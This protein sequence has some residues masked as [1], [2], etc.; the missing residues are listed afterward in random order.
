MSAH[1][2]HREDELLDALGRGYV[3]AELAAHIESCA[4][5]S[6][7]QLVAGALLNDRA[8]AV[9]EAPVPAAGT[10][11]WRMQLRHRHEAQS[12][13]RRTLL[14]GQALTLAIAVGLMVVLFGADVALTVRQLV[15]SIH[16][17][18]PFFLALATSLLLVPIAGWVAI[19]QK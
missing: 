3:G 14:I 7:L 15:G 4:S 19:R 17:G 2:C 1:E 10:M 6:E 13:A 18:T 8:D 12:T 5:C 16:L 11:W 9:A